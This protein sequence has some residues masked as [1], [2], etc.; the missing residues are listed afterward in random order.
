MHVSAFIIYSFHSI[1][2]LNAI[3]RCKSFE[4]LYARQCRKIPK[5]KGESDM[6]IKNSITVLTP[7]PWA[8]FNY[9]QHYH[10]YYNNNKCGCCPCYNTHQQ[11]PTEGRQQ[12]S[13]LTRTLLFFMFPVRTINIVLNIEESRAC[14][15]P[16]NVPPQVP[17]PFHLKISEIVKDMI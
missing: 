17:P 6:T 10:Y 7:D 14:G 8:C 5:R 13:H 15:I 4:D 11:R 16:L 2:L 12:V 9:V 1:W 3:G